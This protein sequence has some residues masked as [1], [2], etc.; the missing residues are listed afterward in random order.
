MM[1]VSR[2]ADDEDDGGWSPDDTKALIALI[3]SLALMF[4]LLLCL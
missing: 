1:R 4:V 3:V 2:R